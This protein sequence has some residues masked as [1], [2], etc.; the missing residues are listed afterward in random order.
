VVLVAGGSPLALTATQRQLNES[1]LPYIHTEDR[2]ST[3]DAVGGPVD[4][5]ALYTSGTAMTY[6][7]VETKLMAYLPK[8]VRPDAEDFL[9]VAF[10]MGTTFRSGLI[11]G[12]NTDAVDLSPTVPWMMPVFYEDAEEFLHHPRA[13]VV[14]A[15]GRNYVRLTSRKYDLITVDPPPPIETAGARVLYSREFYADARRALRPGGV[16]LQWLYFGVDLEELRQHMRTFRSQ[17]PHVLVL[18]NWNDDGVYM[19]GS[20]API[21]WNDATVAR[22]FESPDARADIGSAPNAYALPARPWAEILG[23]MRWL[24]DVEIDGFVGDGPMITDDHPLT[25]YYLL[26]TLSRGGEWVTGLSLRAL[27]AAGVVASPAGPR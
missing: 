3:V 19:L 10:G 6:L 9:V 24:Q 5:R 12:M 27:T 21:A 22:I 18:I 14:A 25:E 7:S 8:V 15:D 13:R 26:H 16:A 1:G 11:L 23:S 2:V 17:F 4:G 20:D